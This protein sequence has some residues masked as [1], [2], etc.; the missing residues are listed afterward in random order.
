MKGIE[1]IKLGKIMRSEALN[2]DV[3]FPLVMSYYNMANIEV[4]IEQA[5]R[6][7]DTRFES[8]CDFNA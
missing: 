4:L 7:Y 3:Y 5:Q 1:V 6:N 2:R 8:D